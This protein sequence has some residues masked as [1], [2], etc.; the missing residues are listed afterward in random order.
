MTMQS[1]RRLSALIV[2]ILATG[3]WLVADQQA[4]RPTASAAGTVPEA[5]TLTIDSIMR[6][7]ALVGSS[8]A[9]VRWSRDSSKVY[10]TWQKAG[11]EKAAP[12]VV[13]R[14]G[15]GLR[16]LTEEE[17]RNLDVPQAGRL[18]RAG[19]RLLMAEGGD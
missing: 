4:G 16:K 14:D 10:F 13:N 7:P 11:D 9:G 12:Y 18:D 1:T 15:S 17:G 19:R 2:L 5:M 3:S 8:P 6:G